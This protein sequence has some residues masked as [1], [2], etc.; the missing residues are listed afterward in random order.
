MI[1]I[2]KK[3]VKRLEMIEIGTSILFNSGHKKLH[4]P[5]FTGLTYPPRPPPFNHMYP[6]PGATPAS[7]LLAEIAHRAISFRSALYCV[8]RGCDYILI[9]CFLYIYIVDVIVCLSIKNLILAGLRKVPG[10]SE[11][12]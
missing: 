7:W 12:I 3:F 9:F 2:L 10:N 4:K 11:I 1:I 8:R 5:C 6:P